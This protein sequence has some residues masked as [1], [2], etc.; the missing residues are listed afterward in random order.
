MLLLHQ[1]Y[2]AIRDRQYQL[3]CSD[4][5]DKRHSVSISCGVHDGNSQPGDKYYND[6]DDHLRIH[7]KLMAGYR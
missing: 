3:R 7:L 5:R 2:Y 4:I 6:I 1:V